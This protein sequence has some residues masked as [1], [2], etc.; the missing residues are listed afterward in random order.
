MSNILIRCLSICMVLFSSHGAIASICWYG[1]CGT[2]SCHIKKDNKLTGCGVPYG[3]NDWCI[4]GSD[5]T[6]YCNKQKNCQ[7]LATSVNGSIVALCH[8][9]Q[10]G[11][12]NEN[13]PKP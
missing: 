9:G 7:K 13:K 12:T 3:P 5:C 8:G 10:V 2:C 4:G 6:D 1:S 11:L